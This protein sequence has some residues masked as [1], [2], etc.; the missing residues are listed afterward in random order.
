MTVPKITVADADFEQ[1]PGQD[2]DVEQGEIVDQRHGGPVT[3]G[4]GRYGASQS[5]KEVIKVDDKMIILD[6]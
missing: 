4:Y 1:T 2:A 5:I 6:R 3:I